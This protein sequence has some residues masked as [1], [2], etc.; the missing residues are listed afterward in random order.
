MILHLK[1]RR[2]APDNGA[3]DGNAWAMP[4]ISS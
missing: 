2:V 1:A 3:T 4:A